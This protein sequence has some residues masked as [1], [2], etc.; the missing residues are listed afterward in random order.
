MAWVIVVGKSF[1]WNA[2]EVVRINHRSYFQHL[3]TNGTP[4]QSFQMCFELFELRYL[5]MCL[6][7]IDLVYSHTLR[8]KK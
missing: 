2:L 7:P 4:R 1:P 8:F 5:K 3:A 6:D